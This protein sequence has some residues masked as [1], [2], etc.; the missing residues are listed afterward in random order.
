MISNGAM[1]RI[2]INATNS[3][4]HASAVSASA[5]NERGSV[6]TNDTALRP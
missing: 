2:P 3:D 1:K 6:M 5:A 4:S